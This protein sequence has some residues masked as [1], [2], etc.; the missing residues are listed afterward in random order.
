MSA[1]LS[2]WSLI[3]E[4]MEMIIDFE[5]QQ[6]VGLTYRLRVDPLLWIFFQVLFP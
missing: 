4:M 3:S 5:A 6:S 2:S 1:D